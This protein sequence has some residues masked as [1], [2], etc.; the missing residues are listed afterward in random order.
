MGKLR[1]RDKGMH[2]VNKSPHKDTIVCVSVVGAP[3]L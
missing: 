3:G 1:I 2:N